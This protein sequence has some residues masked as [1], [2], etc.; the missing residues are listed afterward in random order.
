MTPRVVALNRYLP[1]RPG[2]TGA[3]LR[4]LLAGLKA[5]L[6][7]IEVH[8]VGTDM[9]YGAPDDEE[10]DLPAD[11]TRLTSLQGS[12]G[13][14]ARPLATLHDGWRMARE[15]AASGA[16]VVISLTDPP[17]L[18]H[19]LSFMLHPDQFWIEWS[20]DLFPE[21]LWAAAGRSP[22]RWPP[23]PGRTPDLRLC[24]GPG[25]A[26]FLTGRRG[27]ASPHLILP[28][29]IA[30]PPS[31]AVTVGDGPL[32]LVYAGNMG[33]AHPVEG[34]IALARALDPSRHRWTVHAHGA[35]ANR[36]RTAAAGLSA[37]EWSPA[38]LSREGLMA[39]DVHVAGLSPRWTHVSVPSKAVSA[40]CLGK[41]LLFLG[42]AESDAWRWAGEGGG[43]GAGWRLPADGDGATAVLAALTDPER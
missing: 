30:D 31:T 2:V 40:L 16:Q 5:R 21:A 38:P 20:M 24:L 12:L 28:A 32:R 11:V 27:R 39:A 14:V 35:G 17:M 8:A 10:P 33:R 43:G 6:P 36:F 13:R 41:P 19:W 4:R 15:A 1:P 37:V 26:D 18:G 7:D 34:L 25:Q 22:G 9:A 23:L 29:G 3:L 42:S